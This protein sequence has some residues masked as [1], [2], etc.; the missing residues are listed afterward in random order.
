MIYIDDVTEDCV[1]DMNLV[2]ETIIRNDEETNNSNIS[3]CIE[4]IEE[5]IT[6]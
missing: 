5:L 3:I 1:K 2:E 6:I 4:S